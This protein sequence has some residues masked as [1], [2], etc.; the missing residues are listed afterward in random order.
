MKRGDQNR[1]GRQVIYIYIPV[2]VVAFVLGGHD[3]HTPGI[4]DSS[5][6]D[7]YSTAGL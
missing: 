5:N 7:A 3:S 2:P 6:M 1:K 4:C